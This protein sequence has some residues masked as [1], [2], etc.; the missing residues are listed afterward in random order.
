MQTLNIVQISNY[1]LDYQKMSTDDSQQ[2]KMSTQFQ[3]LMMC[4]HRVDMVLH[5]VDFT[6]LKF[7]TVLTLCWRC[8][9]TVLKSLKFVQNIKFTLYHCPI[10]GLW[11]ESH[12]TQ[13][14]EKIDENYKN[15]F[16][17]PD[18]ISRFI[19]FKMAQPPDGFIWWTGPDW[20]SVR[21][22]TSPTG[23]FGPVLKHRSLLISTKITYF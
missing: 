21:G 11:F 10:W 9:G 7:Y 5:C 19:W 12:W 2:Q 4:W 22:R 6:I 8:V 15:R 23:R 14:F 3:R 17:V 1:D 16:T 20:A 13:I 18:Q